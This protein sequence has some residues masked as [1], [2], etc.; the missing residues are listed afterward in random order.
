MR[1]RQNKTAIQESITMQDFRAVDGVVRILRSAAE[2]ETVR[3]FWAATPGT[4]DSDIDIFFLPRQGKNPHVAQPLVLAIYRDGKPAALLIGKIVRREFVFRVGSLRLGKVM[5]N[6]LTIPYGGLRGEESPEN[7]KRFLG[8]IQ[9]CLKQGEADVALFQYV[10]A[11]SA[12]FRCAKREPN[13]LS[14]D[15]FTPLRPHRKRTLPPGIDKLYVG[16]AHGGKQLRRVANKL[17]SDFSGQLRVD[18]LGNV[19]DLDR[20]LAAVEEIAKTTWQRK[21]SNIGFNPQDAALM[22][23]LRTEA[24][25][26]HLRVYTL[27]LRGTPC[28]FWIGAVYQGTFISDFLGYD[29]EFS[30]YSPGTYLLSQ[31]MEDFCSQGVEEIDFGFSDEEYKRRF[32]NVMWQDANVHVFARTWTGL[33]LS[34]MRMITVLPHEAARTFLK[35]TDLYQIAKRMWRKLAKKKD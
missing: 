11:D 35:R 12:M 15:H 7:C 4:R 32:G 2:I 31:M 10:K 33:A 19:A 23:V 29:P 28:A 21:I 25:G 13:F 3:E 18:R 34:A 6:V 17:A 24:Q 30:H 22:E 20:T 9:N 16:A 5:A 26:G 14:R 27:H 1:K 8:E